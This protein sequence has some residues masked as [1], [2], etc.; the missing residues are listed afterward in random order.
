M[1]LFQQLL[2]GVAFLLGLYYLQLLFFEMVDRWNLFVPYFDALPFE[3]L[4]Y[5]LVLMLFLMAAIIY[6]SD[7][8]HPVY[9]LLFLLQVPWLLFF[10][11]LFV[12]SVPL[13]LFYINARTRHQIIQTKSSSFDCRICIHNGCPAVK[14]YHLVSRLGSTIDFNIYH[15]KT[16]RLSFVF[17]V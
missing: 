7:E 9:A 14:H 16:K 1:R 17:S 4:I 15:K 8:D 10:P 6:L 2:G 11:L 3:I 5:L 13:L 12:P